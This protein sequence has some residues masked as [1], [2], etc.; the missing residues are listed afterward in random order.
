MGG[1]FG[2]V[3]CAPGLGGWADF[4]WA[5]KEFAD[6]SAGYLMAARRGDDLR[7]RVPVGGFKSG[8]VLGLQEQMADI[9]ERGGAAGRDAVGSE[10][11]KEFAED[12]VDIDL[13]D[14]IAGGTGEFFEEIVLAVLGAA[15]G[16]AVV[17]AESLVVGMRRHGT[18]F[19]VGEFEICKVRRVDQVVGC[20]WRI[21]NEEVRYC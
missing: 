9:S 2:G 13:G 20:S 21:I 15:V 7:F 5:G 17:A 18:A 3:V 6:G 16:G 19:A 14:E 10:G 8:A 4:A 1:D 12:V 11:F